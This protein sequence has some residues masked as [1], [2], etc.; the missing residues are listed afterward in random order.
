ML[1]T[2]GVPLRNQYGSGDQ[3]LIAPEC[4]ADWRWFHL[5]EDAFAFEVLDPESGAPVPTGGT[6]V[7]HLTN[8]WMRSFPYLRFCMDDMVTYDTAPCECGRTGM[9]VRIRGRLAWAVQIGDGYVFSQEVED[10]LW[11]R[12]GLAGHDYQLVRVPEA[13]RLIVRVGVPGA[14]RSPTLTTEL[15][16]ALRTAFGVPAEVRVVDPD[17]FPDRA[18]GKAKRVTEA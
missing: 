7:L 4:A 5:P 3:F 10:V 11:A 6:G 2:W 8:L 13:D 15:E 14:E 16:A 1:E 9:R 17:D 18:G 12:P